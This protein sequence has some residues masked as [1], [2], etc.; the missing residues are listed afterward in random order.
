MLRGLAGSLSMLR[1]K[2]LAVVALSAVLIGLTSGDQGRVW[3][4]DKP[5]PDL[6]LTLPPRACAASA[7]RFAIYFDNLILT[8]TPGEYRYVVE[9]TLGKA[10]TKTHW[11]AIPEDEQAGTHPWKLTVFQGEQLL[12][13]GELQIQVTKP[14]EIPQ[15]TRRLLIIGDSLTHATIYPNELSRLLNGIPPEKNAPSAI[16]DRRWKFLGT[17]IPGGANPGVAHEGYGGWTWERFVK[18]YEP[19]PDRAQRKHSSPFV[20]LVED[21]PRLDFARYFQES[22]GGE[23]PNYVTILLGINDCFSAPPED[24]AGIDRRIDQVFT[25]AETL[26][27]AL[28]TAAPQARLGVCLTTPPNARESGFEANYKGAYTRWGWKRIQ[29]RLVQRELKQ[30]GG[31][32]EEGIDII[33]TELFVDPVGGYPVDNG[34]HPNETGYKQIAA[35]IYAWLLAREAADAPRED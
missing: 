11:E 27:A 23:I 32:L 21:Q 10:V 34:V 29:H 30:F 15:R 7:Q 14:Y 22:C 1:E 13:S 24:L 17:H 33:P 31:R 2:M 19:N 3:G 6:Q 4:E 20:F 9:T 35:S 26:L 25:H 5:A 16:A 8:Q 28:R 12:A 18:H